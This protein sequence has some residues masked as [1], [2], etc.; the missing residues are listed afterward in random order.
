M[1]SRRSARVRVAAIL[2]AAVYGFWAPFPVPAAEEVPEAINQLLRTRQYTVAVGELESLARNDHTGALRQLAALY[3]VGRGVPRDPDRTKHYLSRAAELGD[4]ESQFHLGRLLVEGADSAAELNAGLSWLKEA[5]AA[6]HVDAERVYQQALKKSVGSTRATAAGEPVSG[7]TA[8]AR[9]GDYLVNAAE[10]GETDLLGQAIARGVD[11]Q[12]TDQHGRTALTAAV[13]AKRIEAVKLLLANGADVD[14]RGAGGNTAL[15]LAA[16]TGQADIAGVLLAAGADTESRDDGGNTALIYAVDN[17]KLETV[18]ELIAH[19][20]NVNA[21]DSSDWSVLDLARTKGGEAIEDLLLRA[22]ARPRIEAVRN[23][24][25]TARIMATLSD[26]ESRIDLLFEAIAQSN[27]ALLDHLLVDTV[28]LAAL[29]SAG[30]SP[31]GR[32]AQMNDTDAV[33]LLLH[34]GAAVD[35]TDVHGYT[36]VRYAI[37]SGSE[38]LLELLLGAGDAKN[39]A[40]DKNTL[41]YAI[42]S[43]REAAAMALLRYGFDPA[44]RDSKGRDAFTTAARSNAVRV[45]KA[46]AS[47]GHDL[48]GYRDESGKSLFGHAVT[49]DAY[50]A[51]DFLARNHARDDLPRE[52]LSNLLIVAAQHGSPRMLSLV[53]ESGADVNARSD[54]GASA[55]MTAAAVGCLECLEYL[56][57]QGADIDQRDRM[58]NTALHVAVLNGKTSIA[59]RL[60]QAGA[61]RY[62]VN[63]AGESYMSITDHSDAAARK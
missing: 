16:K 41:L 36:P 53:L 30:Y 10:R 57:E 42:R 15:L 49:A 14:A 8:L 45:L 37:D 48:A 50:E 9:P 19:G 59:K 43:R 12:A 7:T 55:L 54:Q 47:A 58:G 32:A 21:V 1:A 46:L 44:V 24:A 27:H 61:D 51:A 52:F 17:G 23:R 13:E 34:H 6:G 60:I 39:P 29:D 40:T 5:A 31:L 2:I 11:V 25:R 3:R 35:A 63:Q 38:E 4:T 56:L 62:M 28:D 26:D 18:R 20:A 22:G 33:R